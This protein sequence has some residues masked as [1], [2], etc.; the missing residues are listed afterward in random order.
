[1]AHRRGDV[2]YAQRLAYILKQQVREVDGPASCVILKIGY[3]LTDE[4]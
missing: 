3:G 4:A 2:G 1:M